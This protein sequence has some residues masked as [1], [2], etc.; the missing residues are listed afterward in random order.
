MIVGL[1]GNVWLLD[2]LAHERFGVLLGVMGERF[3]ASTA[4]FVEE[5]VMRLVLVLCLGDGRVCRAMPGGFGAN[6]GRGLGGVYVLDRL[7]RRL[8]SA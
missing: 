3:G 7:A 4:G 5:L 8:A 6:L 1:F 2:A